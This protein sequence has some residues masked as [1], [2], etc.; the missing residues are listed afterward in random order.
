VHWQP[1]FDRDFVLRRIDLQ[2]P[3]EAKVADNGDAK[4]CVAGTEFREA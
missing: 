1:G 3:I 4:L 2:I